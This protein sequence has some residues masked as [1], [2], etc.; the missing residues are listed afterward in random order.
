ML[1]G[2]L[3]GTI[4]G[5]SVAFVLETLD[6][7]ISGKEDLEAATGTIPNLA[8]VPALRDWRERT[9]TRIVTVERPQSPESEAYRTLRAALEFATVDAEARILQVTSANP[10]EGKTTTAVNLAVTMARNGKRVTLVD[11]DLRKPRLH[12]FFDLPV[13]PG[14]TSVILGQ[15]KASDV[16]HEVER[17]AGVLTIMSSG[18]L[19]PGPSELLGSERTGRVLRELAENSDILIVDS[20]PVLPVSD[21]LVLAKKVDATIL[22]ANGSR[23]R[24]PEIS[25]AVELL[26]QVDARVI[27]TVLNQAKRGSSGYGY[28]YGYGYEQDKARS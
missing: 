17:D 13:E 15:M 21:A 28:G 5:V 22:V 10:G 19:P 14:L 12:A 1:V 24:V 3:L 25:Q 11:A 6:T 7:S 27:G 4:L 16:G 26:S 2:L 23:T 9:T 8:V 18:P 20:A